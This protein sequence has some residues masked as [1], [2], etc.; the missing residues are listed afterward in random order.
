MQQRDVWESAQQELFLLFS[1]LREQTNEPGMTCI[2]TVDTTPHE[3]VSELLRSRTRIRRRRRKR[4]WNVLCRYRL[5]AYLV[6][7]SLQVRSRSS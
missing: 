3:A 6:C 2:S 5:P 7:G 1:E 4:A